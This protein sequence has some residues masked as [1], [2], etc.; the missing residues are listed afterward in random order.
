MS[1]FIYIYIVNYYHILCWAWNRS[2][3][4]CQLCNQWAQISLGRDHMKETFRHKAVNEQARLIIRAQ[5]SIRLSSLSNLFRH[6]STDSKNFI[7]DSLS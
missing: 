2:F 4:P 6:K 5:Y 3:G 1:Q 7:G